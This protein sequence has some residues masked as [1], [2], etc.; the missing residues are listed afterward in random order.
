MVLEKMQKI[1]DI[2]NLE[3]L[4]E[5]GEYKKTEGLLIT[6]Q[7]K[8]IELYFEDE[9]FIKCTENHLLKTKT[10]WKKAKDLEL[11]ESIL[12]KNDKEI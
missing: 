11:Y 1:V 9:S 8:V 4:S 2:S 6:E 5:N 12:D 7:Q 10:G 3:V